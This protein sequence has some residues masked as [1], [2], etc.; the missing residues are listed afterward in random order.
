MNLDGFNQENHSKNTSS[1]LD[2]GVLNNAENCTQDD[3]YNY[4]VFTLL[5][6]MIR[7]KG[8]MG[9]LQR[10]ILVII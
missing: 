10:I 4:G 3:G 8:E 1:S 5:M 6:M 7:H 9:H 2:H